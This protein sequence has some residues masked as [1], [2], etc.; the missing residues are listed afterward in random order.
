MKEKIIEF[1]CE[2]KDDKS[3]KNAITDST[4]LINEIKLNSI[5]IINL[6]I[7]IENEF[8]LEL[9]YED[10]EYESF[11]TIVSL[12]KLIESKLQKN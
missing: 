5:E 6:M 3:L 11:K 12:E 7:S 2:A 10:I 9:E 1:I 8:D 4:D